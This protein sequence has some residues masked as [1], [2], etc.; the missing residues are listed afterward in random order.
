VRITV[1]AVE[2]T[3]Q[4]REDHHRINHLPH[5]TLDKEVSPGLKGRGDCHEE[6]GLQDPPFAMASLEPRVWKLNG[7]P[8]QAI[9]GQRFHPPFQA[10]IGV[11]KQHPHVPMGALKS[12]AIGRDHQ[13]AP[14]FDPDV[15]PIR[16]TVGQTQNASTPCASD[17]EM[18]RVIGV[19]E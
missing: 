2:T 9:L 14:N 10:D 3:R 17:V 18:D 8:L 7:H 6:A 13:G 19:S 15:V 4:F 1:R 12:F 5:I 16:M 11:A